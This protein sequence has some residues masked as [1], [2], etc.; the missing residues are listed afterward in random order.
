MKEIDAHVLV[1]ASEKRSKKIVEAAYD[2]A[3]SVIVDPVKHMD[4]VKSVASDFIEG[5]YYV[6]KNKL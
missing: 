4:A 2:Y 5:A 3:L 6:L 1:E